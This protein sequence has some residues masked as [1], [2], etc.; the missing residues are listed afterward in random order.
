[1]LKKQMHGQ[2]LVYLDSAATTQ[3]PQEVI[4]TLKAF[5]EEHYG[6]RCGD[7]IGRA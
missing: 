7:G 4:D 3:K 6:R 1:M 5:Y 2:P